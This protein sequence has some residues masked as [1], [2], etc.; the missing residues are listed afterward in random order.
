MMKSDKERLISIISTWKDLKMQIIQN[1]ITKGSL[2]ENQFY[3]WAVTTPLY[4]IGEQI[5]KVINEMHD[6]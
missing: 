3:Q 5:E 2:L 6:E 1:G 4:N